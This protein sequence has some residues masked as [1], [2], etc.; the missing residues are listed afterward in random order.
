ML[1]YDIVPRHCNG[2]MSVGELVTMACDVEVLWS[3]ERYCKGVSLTVMR[4]SL[5]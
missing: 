4:F 2:M 3:R 1:K 5:R